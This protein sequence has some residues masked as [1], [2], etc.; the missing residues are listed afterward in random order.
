VSRFLCS[1]ASAARDEPVLGTASRVDRW[2]LVEAPGP[3]GPR[4]LPENREV[5]DPT[6]Q[7]LQ[8]RAK[9]AH[10]RTLLIRRPG[11]AVDRD[12]AGRRVYVADSRPGHERV[13]G[14][15]VLDDD[16]LDVAL[17]FDGEAPGWL[18]E[19]RLVAVCTQG[20]HD[21]CCAVSGRP[22]A[23]AL[24]AAPAWADATWEVSHIGGDRF[25][26]NVLLL[27]GG[28]YLG[29]VEPE[30]VVEALDCLTAGVR[31]DPWYRGRACWS[32]PVQ[33]AL[34]LIGE[35]RRIASLDGLRPLRCER[36]AEHHWRVD[37][38]VTASGERVVTDLLQTHGP[39]AARL[40]C[41][42][43]LE[44]PVPAWRLVTTPC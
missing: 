16:L 1:A 38:M 4:A 35:Q 41:H 14:R 9:A 44:R 20:R 34:A 11:G 8:L 33:A 3:W 21:T 24:A 7:A 27:P 22:V 39:D 6:L 15:R 25:A 43:Q 37:L 36:V 19:D 28:H 32:M 13:L 42:A 40:T 12:P 23:A 17:P 29:R 31:P 30:G 10:A 2:L 5:D 26:A 18:A